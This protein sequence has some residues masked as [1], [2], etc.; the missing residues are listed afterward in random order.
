MVT[1][2]LFFA[3][4]VGFHG[5][6]ASPFGYCIDCPAVADYPGLWIGLGGILAALGGALIGTVVRRKP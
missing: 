2:G 3:E 6:C 5:V 1:L 4:I